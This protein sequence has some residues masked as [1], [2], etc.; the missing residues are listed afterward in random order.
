MKVKSIFISDLHLGTK[1]ESK[2]LSQFLSNWQAENYYLLG[3]IIDFWKLSG[4]P[5]LSNEHLQIIKKI[6]KISKKANV[7]YIT[8]NHDDLLRGFDGLTFGNIPVYDEYTYQTQGR[9]YLLTHGDFYDFIAHY[10]IL[11]HVGGKAYTVLMRMSRFIQKIQRLFGREPW[12][13]S[14]FIKKNL[15]RAVTHISKFEHLLAMECLEKG[16]EGVICGHIHMPQNKTID[17]IQYINC[18]DFQETASA[19]V[20][21][22]NGRFEIV[23]L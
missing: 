23:F 22:H 13:F 20:E 18:G 14:L 4:N 17:G 3:D 12:S 15:K 2:K 21:H 10:P 5:K 6:I 11:M 16:Y 9:R 19:V 8:G 1:M 7:V